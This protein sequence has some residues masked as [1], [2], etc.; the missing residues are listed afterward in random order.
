MGIEGSGEKKGL[1]VSP[2]VI[3]IAVVLLLAFLCLAAMIITG[4]VT[5]E[6]TTLSQLT[7]DVANSLDNLIALLIGLACA[8]ELVSEMNLAKLFATPVKP[9]VRFLVTIVLG[10]LIYQPLAFILN[11]GMTFVSRY[12]Y[13]QIGVWGVLEAL[14]LVVALVVVYVLMVRQEK[15]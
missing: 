7:I 15:E 11:A 10:Y 6:D 14:L 2:A 4:M 3:V 12:R 1:P 5:D 8:F 13:W 9:W